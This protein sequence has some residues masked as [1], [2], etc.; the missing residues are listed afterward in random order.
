M[1]GFRTLIKDKN[2]IICL[3]AQFRELLQKQALKGKTNGD[4]RQI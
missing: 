1:R 3:A 4:D 2:P